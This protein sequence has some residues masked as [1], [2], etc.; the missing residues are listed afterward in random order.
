MTC[1]ICKKNEATI[2]YKTNINGK[3]TEMYLCRECAEKNGIGK[4]TVFEPIDVI[5]GFLGKGT[6]DIFGGLFA[7]M[8]NNPVSKA[9]NEPKVCPVCKMR[10]SDF[11]HGG[12]IGCAECYK[13]FSQPLSSTVKRIHGSAEHCGKIPS[14]KAGEIT[15]KRKIEELKAKLN[16]A[17]VNQEYELAAEYRDEI[18]ALENKMKEVN[19]NEMV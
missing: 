4:K 11:L 14:D 8:T 10:F 13:I 3:Q 6:D 9:V 2:H 12:K 17:V 1:Q 15:D 19:G 18:R 7:G 16:S 5:D